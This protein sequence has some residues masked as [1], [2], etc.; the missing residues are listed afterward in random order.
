MAGRHR[1]QGEVVHRRRGLV[2]MAGAAVALLVGLAPAAG[3]APLPV[4][5]PAASVAPAA[6]AA[7]GEAVDPTGTTPEPAPLP[8][9]PAAEPVEEVP[10]TELLV[11]FVPDVPEAQ[12]QAVLSAQG[13]AAA[14]AIPGTDVV[15]VP[16]GDQDPAALAA[17]LEADP[18]VAV[19]EP[20]HV[21]SA[22]LWPDDP[23]LLDY[24]WPMFDLQRFPRAWDV[25]G[26]SGTV[27]AVLDTG[28]YAGHEDLAGSVMTGW[29][30]V[31][32]DSDASDDRGHGTAVAGVAAAHAG[33][34][35]GFAGAAWGAYILP[36]KVLDANGNGN[37]ATVAQGIRYAA[38]RGADV[39]NLS[40][41]GPGTSSVLRDAMTYAVALGS[42]VVIAAGNDGSDVA[43]YPAAYAP[44]IDGVLAVGAT[45]DYGS[46][47]SFSSWGD[48][49]TLAA[50]G[51]EVGVPTSDGDYGLADGT[52]F[53]APFVSG[54]AALL[55]ARGAGTPALVEHVLKA[56]ARDAGPR[57]VDPFYGAGVL[58]VA[59]ALGFGTSVPLDRMTGDTSA[60]DGVP[61]RARAL[62]GTAVATLAPEGDEDWYRFTSAS[63]GWHRVTVS[64]L[65]QTTS[66][67]AAIDAQIEVRDGDGNHLV[68]VDEMYPNYAE[69]TVVELPPGEA[70]LVGVSN[71][72]GSASTNRYSVTV[73]PTGTPGAA[74]P[75]APAW[76]HQTNL[77]P[78][79]AGVDVRPTLTF[80]SGHELAPGAASASTVRLLDGG[81]GYAVAATVGYDAASRTISLKPNAN[82]TPGRHYTVLVSGLTDTTAGVQTEPYRTWFTVAANG[83]R[84]TPVEPRRVLDTRNG[85]GASGA[86]RPGSP[87]QLALGG[88][89][90]PSDATAVVLN[91]T[92]VGPS[93]VGNVRV[94]PTPAGADVPPTISNLNVVQGVDQPNLVTVTLGRDGKVS[95]AT[96]GTA[97]HLIADVAGYYSKGGATAF[98]PLTP[99]RVMDTRN[100]TGGVPAARV[101][102]GGWVDLV[103]T[104]RNGVPADANAVVLNVTGV[105]PDGRTNVRVYPTPAASEHQG[106]PSVSNLNLVAGRD[107]PNLVTVAVGDGGRVRF[108]TQSATVSLVADLAGY[109]SPTG[110]HGYVPLTPTRIADTRSGLGFPQGPI[111]AGA[112]SYL[113]VAGANG[114]PS[115]AAA[116]VLNVTAVS[117]QQRSNVRV[118][119]TTVPTV[120]PLVSNLNVVAGRD[121]PNLAIV[122]LG[123]QGRV[124]V[125]SQSA[126]LGMVVDIAGYFTR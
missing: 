99:V 91:V 55:V 47:T 9:I 86:V 102:A 38:E 53:A 8:S 7:P 68:T 31:N 20:N 112:T 14:D 119:P 84:F 28:V 18:R 100:G 73:T 111:V 67:Q 105:A 10:P 64:V 3:A 92:A 106:P 126:N 62:T 50:P 34:G 97:A 6:P 70:L 78:H 15:V 113:K 90:V 23:Y 108:Y 26:G 37:D 44:E 33:N 101:S 110:D 43:Q 87:A 77:T 56:T 81:T 93:S 104:D 118:F 35:L 76:V 72:N 12:E 11:T 74:T 89:E 58:D 4:A 25:G 48:W 40:L 29:D 125:Y 114:V 109:Y 45:D 120:V 5:A 19:V 116:A 80:T 17:E 79:S 39:I 2:V 13:T 95:L 124:S 63:A 69:S 51:L 117:P 24:T 123:D 49:V 52:S 96:D 107:Q 27:I 60:E 54:A 121:E 30:F 41:G 98:V 1:N 82:L 32:S 65:D 16:V 22:S 57:G 42:V 59:A 66:G 115:T 94:Y 103:V 122:R 88:V 21:R 36:V 75:G 46:L 83:Q 61:A 71:V 85:T